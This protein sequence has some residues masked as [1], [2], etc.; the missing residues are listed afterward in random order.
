MQEIKTKLANLIDYMDDFGAGDTEPRTVVASILMYLRE[1]KIYPLE[2]TADFWE[3]YGDE[4]GVELVAKSINDKMTEIV[5][6]LRALGKD[7]CFEILDVLFIDE[8]CCWFNMY[9]NHWGRLS[10]S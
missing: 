7:K 2:G 4:P 8:D 1:N 3:L 10:N 5:E 9:I 6:A